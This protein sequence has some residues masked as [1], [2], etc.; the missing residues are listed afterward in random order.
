[1]RVEYELTPRRRDQLYGFY[2]GEW[3]TKHRTTE[4]ADAA[5]GASY[6]A[7]VID[8]DDQVVGFARALSDG[9]F[10]AWVGDVIAAPGSRG[11]GVGAAI[12]DAIVAHPGL[13]SVRKWD[14]SCLPELDGFYERWGFADPAP[15]HTRRRSA[16]EHW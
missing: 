15:S 16:A 2:F 10:F 11:T 12:M 7:L 4:E 5:L 14:L 3:W 8:E 13:R 6:V 1:M 9:V